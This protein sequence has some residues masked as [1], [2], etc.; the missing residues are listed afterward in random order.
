MSMEIILGVLADLDPPDYDPPG[1]NPLVD[2]DPPPRSNPLAEVACNG[3]G[4][5]NWKWPGGCFSWSRDNVQAFSLMLGERR[6]WTFSQL[7][8]IRDK[9][10][11]LIYFV[12]VQC[13]IVGT[14]WNNASCARDG[15]TW[16]ARDLRL[17]RKASGS[18]LSAD[19]QTRDVFVTVKVLFWIPQQLVINR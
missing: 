3:I 11:T 17:T 7:D 14:T 9:L 10:V 13:P 12:I 6:F 8:S 18:A 5:G 16:A 1:P 19:R 15:Y 4:N 2:I